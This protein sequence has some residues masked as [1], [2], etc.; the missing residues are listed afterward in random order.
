MTDHI[1][2]LPDARKL[3]YAM[4]GPENGFPVFYFHG[5]PSSRL[6]PLLLLPF[7]IDI[8]D[9]LT[10]YNLQFIAIDRPGI[11]KSE[12]NKNA[13]IASF[14]KDVKHLAEHLHIH[15]AASLAWS[16]G[17][18]YALSQAYQFHNLIKSV[19][20]IAGFTKSIHEKQVFKAM[21][22]N[23][24]YFGAAKYVPWLLNPVLSMAGKLNLKRQLP[25]WLTRFPHAD[26][27][28]FKDR[29]K[30]SVFSKVTIN[31]ACRKNSKGVVH[32]A[33]LYFNQNDYSLSQLVQPVHYWWGTSDNVVVAIH[34]E[35]IQKEVPR[36]HLHLKEGEGHFSIYVNYIKEVL[37]Q[38][39]QDVHLQPV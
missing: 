26:H 25:L 34:N 12:Y 17:G 6:E 31:E 10:Q 2:Y 19:Y 39:S 20:I 29:E 24:Y 33:R 37:R 8:D 27:Y 35:A 15:S 1:F 28:L 18:P 4:Y 9:L 5:T 14:A 3:A 38:I 7:G 21:T 23:K 32:E 13:T 36:H 30:M 22:A 11:G 16:G